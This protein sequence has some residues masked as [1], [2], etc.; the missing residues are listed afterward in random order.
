LDTTRPLLRA[1]SLSPSRFRAA[2]RGPSLSA[3]IGGSVTYRLSEPAAV[4]FRV[5]RALPGRSVRGRCVKRRRSNVR[6]RRCSRYVTLRGSFTQQGK[7]GQNTFAFSGRLR[8][9]KLGPGRYRLRAVATDPAG[10]ESR[11][12]SS[13]FRIVRR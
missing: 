7:T 12:K 9:R 10:N 2:G 11:P 13:R 6:A 5:E 4:S 3:R 1:L 8:A